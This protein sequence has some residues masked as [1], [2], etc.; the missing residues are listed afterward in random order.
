[1]TGLSGPVVLAKK[2]DSGSGVAL[3]AVSVVAASI[4]LYKSI[5][6]EALVD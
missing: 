3:I 2:G 5:N 6:C 4:A 1:M